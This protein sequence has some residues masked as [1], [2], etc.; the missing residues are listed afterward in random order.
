[1]VPFIVFHA[2]IAACLRKDCEYD[3]LG[4]FATTKPA[5]NV[6]DVVKVRDMGVER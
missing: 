1:M 6:F 3:T 4:D 2:G 5:A